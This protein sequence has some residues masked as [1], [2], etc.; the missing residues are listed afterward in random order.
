MRE[1]LASDCAE[2]E[3][4][5]CSELTNH[6]ECQPLDRPLSSSVADRNTLQCAVRFD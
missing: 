2:L 1:S 6:A 4:A 5:G 3:L